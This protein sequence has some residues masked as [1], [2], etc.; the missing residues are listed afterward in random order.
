MTY[1]GK[2]L[3]ALDINRINI[4]PKESQ[5]CR[6]LSFSFPLNVTASEIQIITAC[7]PPTSHKKRKK[8]DAWTETDIKN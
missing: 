7:V 1:L 4:L 3:V 2:T 6:G 5:S 8:D